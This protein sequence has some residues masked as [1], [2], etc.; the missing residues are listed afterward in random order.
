MHVQPSLMPCQGDP[1]RLLLRL[2]LHSAQVQ[3]LLLM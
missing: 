3:Q 1:A 2:D